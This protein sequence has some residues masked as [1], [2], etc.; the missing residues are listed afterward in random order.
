MCRE[1]RLQLAALVNY[2]VAASRAPFSAGLW[3]GTAHGLR[4]EGICVPGSS[5]GEAA[6]R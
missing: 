3:H 2:M 5:L 4:R 6:H 1:M